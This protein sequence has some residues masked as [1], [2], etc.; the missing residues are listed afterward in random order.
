[1]HSDSYLVLISKDETTRKF[2]MPPKFDPLTSSDV[3]EI[4]RYVP[5]RKGKVTRIKNQITDF[6]NLPPSTNSVQFARQIQEDLKQSFIRLE[7]IYDRIS[8]LSPTD[9]EENKISLEAIYNSSYKPAMDEIQTYIAKIC[10]LAPAESREPP[11]P[12]QITASSQKLDKFLQPEKLMQSHTPHHLRRWERDLRIIFESGALERRPV[13][14][15][16]QYAF[17]CRDETLADSLQAKI[18][19][20]T[21]I[22][23]PGSMMTA[24]Y[25]MFETQNPIF[26]RQAEYFA[27]CAGPD[28]TDYAR[29]LEELIIASRE[30]KL[31]GVTLE[32]LNVHRFLES[33]DNTKIREKIMERP[34][35]TLTDVR[36]VIALYT[37][38][39]HAERSLANR[40]PQKATAVAAIQQH[41]NNNNTSSPKRQR[42]PRQPRPPPPW[43]ADLDN[44]C[45]G[46]G[47]K[48][49]GSRAEKEH[50][51]KA[52]NIECSHC[53]N[54][55]HYKK[56]C[57]N[58][59]KAE[60]ESR[61]NEKPAADNK[62]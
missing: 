59:R 62:I 37:K 49:H 30:A 40:A 46:C 15:Q 17:K 25:D 23:G 6:V 27:K 3:S 32:E 42:Q 52:E 19:P 11:Q 28:C 18:R 14:M 16:Q 20:T 58:Y 61:K 33:C 1:M 31:E 41:N 38:Q 43:M 47:G 34:H 56:Y 55:G 35:P 8:D 29:Y 50:L 9:Y 57:Y 26:S 4:K 53:H 51:C 10:P 60:H 2:K 44:L 48:T 13:S 45:W 39:T 24:L 36:S 21:A 22:F 7:E 12:S 54:K 5:S